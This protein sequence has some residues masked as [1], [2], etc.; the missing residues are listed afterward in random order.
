MGRRTEDSTTSKTAR[1]PRKI[2]R[3]S[4]RGRSAA[5]VRSWG[6]GTRGAPTT[7]RTSRR[8]ASTRW[9]SSRTTKRAAAW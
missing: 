5:S 8:G 4:R 1:G 7:R 9:P 3:T 2:S 6:T